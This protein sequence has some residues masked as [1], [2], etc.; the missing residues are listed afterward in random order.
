MK[1]DSLN[2]LYLL[3]ELNSHI[4]DGGCPS[5]LELRWNLT[6]SKVPKTVN[7]V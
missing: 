7:N 1:L 5:R 4:G 2:I 6:L 3:E